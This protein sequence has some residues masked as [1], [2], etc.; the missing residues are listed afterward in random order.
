MREDHLIVPVAIG[1]GSFLDVQL[2][3]K[4]VT[5]FRK[6]GEGILYKRRNVPGFKCRFLQ[7]VVVWTSKTN[8]LNGKIYTHAKYFGSC[9]SVLEIAYLVMS[10]RWLPSFSYMWCLINM[11]LSLWNNWSDLS[12]QYILK[13]KGIL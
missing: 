6:R 8:I 11:P 5:N 2:I 3:R 9:R 13:V 10:F 12:S 4:L 7:L 1:F